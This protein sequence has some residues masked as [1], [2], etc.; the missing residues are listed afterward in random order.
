MLSPQSLKIRSYLFSN[1][2]AQDAQVSLPGQ[3]AWFDTMIEKYAGHPI[4]L[5]EGTRVESV[6][7]D[8]IPAEWIVF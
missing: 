7:V 2:T 6:N 1:N 4:P 8:G 3:R 5:P